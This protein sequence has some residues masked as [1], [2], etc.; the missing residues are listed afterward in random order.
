MGSDRII[1]ADEFIRHISKSVNFIIWKNFPGVSSDKQ[2]DISQE[3]NLKIWKALKSGKN[4]SN[5]RSYLWKVVHTTALDF[6]NERMK[7]VNLEKEKEFYT[8][9][10]LDEI[11]E[12]SVET[13][14]EKKEAKTLLMEAVNTLSQNRR[15]VIKL[16]LKGMNIK[17]IADFLGWSKSK[18]NHLYYRG[19]EDLRKRIN[20][21]K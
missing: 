6:I 17:E 4:I 19:L 9:N 14:H 21:V 2:A 12:I 8:V 7:Y 1:N 10:C 15:I 3:V 13:L 18:V 5:L 20:K 16:S 11:K